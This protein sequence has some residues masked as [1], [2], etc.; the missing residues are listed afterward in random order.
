V[1]VNTAVMFSSA[2]PEWETPQALFDRLATRHGGFTLDVC[3]TP[4]NAKCS[5]YFTPADDGLLQSWQGHRCWMNPPYGREIGKWVEK[6]SFETRFGGAYV[7]VALLPAR[8]DTAWFHEHI[9]RQPH[10]HVEF[11]RGRVRFGNATAGAPFPSMVVAF[12]GAA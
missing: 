6:A 1:A 3:A 12:N 9:Y 8:T 10:T 2:T 7:V 11:L 4:E 5:R